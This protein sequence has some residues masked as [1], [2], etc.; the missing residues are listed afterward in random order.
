MMPRLVSKISRP[1]L[2]STSAT[3]TPL[4]PPSAALA[5]AR[6][7]ASGSSKRTMPRG[8]PPAPRTTAELETTHWPVSAERYGCETCTSPGRVPRVARKKALAR[9]LR[10]SEAA[11]AGSPRTTRARSRPSRPMADAAPTEPG[12]ARSSAPSASFMSLCASAPA[13][14]MPPAEGRVAGQQPQRQARASEQPA[15]G[16]GLA[17]GLEREA[18]VEPGARL[19][20]LRDRQRGCATSASRR[21]VTSA[22]R[23][24]LRMRFGALGRPRPPSA[25]AAGPPNPRRGE[26]I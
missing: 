23:V 14:G 20:V 8:T 1:L 5:A 21:L 12:S 11:G 16:V 6:T 22:V 26:R 25:T 15:E 10:A 24:A 2:R 4:S 18:L 19:H 3:W 7:L 9:T 13:P 17:V